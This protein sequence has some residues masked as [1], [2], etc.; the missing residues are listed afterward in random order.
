MRRNRVMRC[1]R[2]AG[3]LV[4]EVAEIG[5][6]DLLMRRCINCG[7][8]TEIGLS[9]SRHLKAIPPL[10]DGP[11]NVDG[12]HRTPSSRLEVVSHRDQG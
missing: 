1:S 12:P 11:R 4:H 2:C 10:L 5:E 3:C 9:R 6:G 7:S 8:R